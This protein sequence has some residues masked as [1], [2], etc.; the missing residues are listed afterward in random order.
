MVWPNESFLNLRAY[1]IHLR[2][3]KENGRFFK[4][5][6]SII[7]TPFVFVGEVPSEGIRH[8]GYNNSEDLR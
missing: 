4:C 3:A 2:K 8:H 1:S 5:F 6:E 7:E